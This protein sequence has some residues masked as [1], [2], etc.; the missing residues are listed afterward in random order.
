MRLIDADALRSELE[1][2]GMNDYDPLDFIEELDDAPTVEIE[3]HENE[4]DVKSHSEKEIYQGCIRLMR[5]MVDYFEEYLYIIGMDPEN[6]MEDEKFSVAF[7][8]FEIVQDLFLYGT[9][10]SG[11][12]STRKKCRELGLDDSHLVEFLF[13]DSNADDK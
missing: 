9:S 13:K 1:S 5:R 12:T 3:K 4:E 8:N 11:G 2:W 6:L 7:S 10:H